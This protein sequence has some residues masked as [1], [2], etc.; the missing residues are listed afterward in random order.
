MQ[1]CN[2]PLPTLTA[3]QVE[4]L[5]SPASMASFAMVSKISKYV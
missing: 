3:A 5:S 2:S 4:S 1:L